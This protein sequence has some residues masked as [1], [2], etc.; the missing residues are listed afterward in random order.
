MQNIL[1]W[2]MNLKELVRE[3]Y[4]CMEL[5]G[6]VSSISPGIEDINTIY[7]MYVKGIIEHSS[8]VGHS[9][10]KIETLRRYR[11]T[12]RERFKTYKKVLQL[13]DIQTI[14]ERKGTTLSNI[15]KKSIKAPK[16]H[17]FFY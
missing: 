2:D 1:S 9:Q 6:K 12:L 3:A 17:A 7:I 15:S 14:Y 5:L 8:R 16:I 4:A 10:K 13:L 11:I